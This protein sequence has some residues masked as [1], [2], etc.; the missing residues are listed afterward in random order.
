MTSFPRKMPSRDG[1]ALAFEFPGTFWEPVSDIDYDG[2]RLRIVNGEGDD[3][4]CI[5]VTY[6][7]ADADKAFSACGRFLGELCWFYQVK[8]RLVL[9]VRGTG[10]PTATFRREWSENADRISLKNFRQMVIKEVDHLALAFYREAF[11][12][13]SPFYRFLS[14]FK[15]IE[16]PFPDGK[17]RSA[18]IK[19]AIPRLNGA[20]T[21]KRYFSYR[22]SEPLHEWIYSK[23][24]SPLAHGQVGKKKV[25]VDPNRFDDWQN[26]A[27]G[28]VIVGELAQLCMIEVLGIE[29]PYRGR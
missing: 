25:Q 13:E 10:S 6:A 4:P 15:V 24:R 28:S 21:A 5:K 29:A 1:L 26:I 9:C 7:V 20:E 8:V 3:A 23:G 27:W 11:A 16:I 22:I 2:F 18:W 19:D 12:N 17:K 14:Y